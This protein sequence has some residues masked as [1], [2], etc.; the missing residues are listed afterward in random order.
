MFAQAMHLKALGKCGTTEKRAKTNSTVSL[1]VDLGWILDSKDT[2][3]AADVKGACQEE[4][5]VPIDI[6][7][8]TLF[9]DALLILTDR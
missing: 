3:E 7:E 2:M 1:C 9:L 4:E 5:V 6:P 8:I